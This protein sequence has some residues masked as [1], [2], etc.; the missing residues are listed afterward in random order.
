MS[1]KIS[2]FIETLADNPWLVIVSFIITVLAFI[3]GFISYFKSKKVKKP[4]LESRSLNL[5]EESAEKI[6]GL[7]IT[8][9]NE[10]IPN[11]TITK[12][13]IWNDGNDTIDKNDIASADPLLITA[14]DTVHILEYKIIY[15]KNECS[16]FD[17]EEIESG[18][19]LKVTFDFL[20]FHDGAVI[21]L[22]HTGNSS[23]DIEFKGTIKGVGKIS[24]NHSKNKVNSRIKKIILK[25]GEK[26]F[27][28]VNGIIFII[29]GLLLSIT[30]FVTFF[31]LDNI[32]KPVE[33]PML[34]FLYCILLSIVLI[35]TGFKMLKRRVPKGFEIF[36]ENI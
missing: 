5:L 28:R 21:Q 14:K 35:F 26:T 3:F 11:L 10:N 22:L 4:R 1:Q 27:F 2:I 29:F 17:I 24:T 16:L 31:W 30:E 23:S 12:L 33:D 6:E 18:K 20:D 7:K 36:D 34:E 8:Y 13:A 9:L 15:Q 32:Y 25:L 19:Q